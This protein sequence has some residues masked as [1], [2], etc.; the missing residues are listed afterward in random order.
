MFIFSSPFHAGLVGFQEAEAEETWEERVQSH[1]IS[2]P[3]PSSLSHCIWM[4]VHI[5][6]THAGAG[7]DICGFAENKHC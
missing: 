4:H 1:D 6:S 3:A 7:T 5:V 2:K